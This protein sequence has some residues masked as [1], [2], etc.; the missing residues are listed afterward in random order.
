MRAIP[1]PSRLGI[2]SRLRRARRSMVNKV[3][4]G[5]RDG[6]LSLPGPGWSRQRIARELSVDCPTAIPTFSR[7]AFADCASPARLPGISS[8]SIT[9]WSS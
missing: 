7:T 2:H 5:I 4:I 8:I 9:G 1:L 6:I 3:R